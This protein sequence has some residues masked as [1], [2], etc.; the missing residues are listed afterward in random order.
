MVVIGFIFAWL[1]RDRSSH[2]SV[3]LLL[4]IVLISIEGLT[5]QTSFVRHKEATYITTTYQNISQLKANMASEI[6]MPKQKDLF[7]R[8]F[9]LPDKI[10]AGS[11]AQGDIHNLHFTY[12]KWFFTNLSTGE[13]DVLI[14][15][16]GE[17]HIQTRI[18]KN[19]AYMSH[20]ANIKGTDVYFTPLDNG[21]TKI[22][23]TVKYERLLDPYW[24]FGPLQQLAAE[25]SAKYLVENI[26][27]KEG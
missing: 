19:T 16:V 9:P 22:S 24:Y 20:Y 12:K 10:K 7:L 15:K 11:L 27:A 17:K 23:L 13:M 6:I 21:K 26:I 4:I 14:S 1:F 25:Q 5:P 18:I 8:L 2:K 3:S